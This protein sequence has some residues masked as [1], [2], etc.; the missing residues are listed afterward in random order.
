MSQVTENKKLMFEVLG[1]LNNRLKT[2]EDQIVSMS[3][4]RVR[5]RMAEALLFLKATYGFEED[6][7]TINIKLS[8]EEL[9]DYVGTSTESSIRLLSDFGKE[10]LIELRG[11]KIAILD[12]ATLTKIS[13][14]ED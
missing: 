10:G 6:N 13:R 9:A 3:Q 11:K 4:K 1:K 5:E 8:R 2:A 14:I 12:D 7:Q